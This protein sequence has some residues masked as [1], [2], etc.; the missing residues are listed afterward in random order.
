VPFFRSHLGGFIPALLLII[1]AVPA[2][3]DDWQPIA[4]AE[5]KMT[6]EPMAPGASAILLYRQVDRDDV[7]FREHNYARIKILNEE[8]RKYANLEFSFVQGHGNISGIHARTIQP[9]GAIANF[10]GKVY[11]KTIVKT[12]GGKYLAKTFTLPDVQVGTIIEYRYTR[13]LELGYV[14]DSRWVLSDELFTKHANFS[15]KQNPRYALRISWPMGLPPGTAQPT[16]ER[17]VV[18]LETHN[19]PAFEVEDYMPPEDQVKLRVDFVYS[20]SSE[21]NPEKFWKHIGTLEYAGIEDFINKRKAME[22]AVSRIVA[23]NDTLDMKLRKIYTRAQQIRNLSI[24]REKTENEQNREKLQD[25]NN[26]EDIWKHGYASGYGTTWL[27]L[28][29]V[30]AAGFDAYPVLVSTRDR[31]FFETRLMNSHEL[32]TNAVLVK[33]DGKDLFFDPG[34]AFAPYGLLPWYESAVPGLRLD[35]D[36]GGWVQVAGSNSSQSRIE[37]K[38]S[39]RLNPDSGELEGKLTVTFTGMQAFLRRSEEHDEDDA[40]RKK[41]LEDEVKDYIPVASEVELT[42]KPDWNSSSPTL[43]AEFDLKVT[44]WVTPAGRRQLIAIGL[45]GKEEKHTFEHTGRVH[46]I[47]FHFPFQLADDVIVDLP[48]DWQT[49]LPPAQNLGG[50]VV[51][52]SFTVENKNGALHW[53][54]Q[55]NVNTLLLPKEYYPS[56]RDFYQSVRTA[57]EQQIV[58]SPN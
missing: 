27:F 30:R 16:Q 42:S 55:F 28:A 40:A 54:R 26:V 19:V 18:R 35:K 13:E 14:F 58:L 9:N 1:L 7:E 24:E 41:F 21:S 6:S 47:Y 12:R 43:V 20:A 37:R 52:Y 56:L 10:D 23:P 25:N 33:L 5:L 2:F 17:E 53:T 45:F 38:A 46:P 11:E 50:K 57:D 32:N 22:E 36:G 48:P 15:L 44:G 31:Y 49:T 39:L 29:L 8:G 51:G 4:P 34:A 3:S